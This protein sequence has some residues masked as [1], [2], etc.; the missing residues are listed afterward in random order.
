MRGKTGAPAPSYAVAGLVAVIGGY[1]RFVSPLLGPRCRFAPTCSSYA[2]Q[3][4]QRHG[5]GRGGWLALRR[6][7]RCHPFHPGGHDP[8]PPAR[9]TGTTPTT[10]A[11]T[12]ILPAPPATHPRTRSR[13]GAPP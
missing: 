1:Q 6:L 11:G 13:A 12:A 3:A 5:L 4:L 8:V 9:S 7:G 2:V 10:P